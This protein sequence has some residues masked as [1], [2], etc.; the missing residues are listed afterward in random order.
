[1]DLLNTGVENMKILL[2]EVEDEFAA[3]V[4]DGDR[5]DDFVRH[6]PNLAL[7]RRHRRDLRLAL[8]QTGRGRAEPE[9][10]RKQASKK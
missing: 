4:R 8:R 7:R 9:G 2:R 6:H 1:M 10:Q 5:G 3:Q